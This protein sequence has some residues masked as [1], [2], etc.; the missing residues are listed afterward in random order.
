[1]CIVAIHYCSFQYMKIVFSTKNLLK[2]TEDQGNMHKYTKN[3]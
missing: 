2:D 3:V 1:M